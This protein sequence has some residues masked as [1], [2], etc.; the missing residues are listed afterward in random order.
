MSV[1]TMNV[2]ANDWNDIVQKG[3]KRAQQANL[4]GRP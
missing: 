4:G 1:G 3:Q 2:N